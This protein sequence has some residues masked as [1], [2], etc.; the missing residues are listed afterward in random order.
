MTRLH[1]TQTGLL[2]FRCLRSWG[3]GSSMARWSSLECPVYRQVLHKS[4][5]CQ[6]RQSEPI[7]TLVT[8]T[9]F[10]TLHEGRSS[11]CYHASCQSVPQSSQHCM[12]GGDDVLPPCFRPPVAVQN[13][14][15]RVTWSLFVCEA[16]NKLNCA[17]GLFNA[18]KENYCLKSQ[19]SANAVGTI[20]G[21]SLC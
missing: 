6:V 4:L 12:R 5:T 10:L 7:P 16:K 2:A 15:M 9:V 1:L 3:H 17:F 19:C 8:A 21:I 13:V 14:T 11:M 20:Y 18:N